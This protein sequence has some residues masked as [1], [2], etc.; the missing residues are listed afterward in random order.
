MSTKS[1]QTIYGGRIIGADINAKAAREETGSVAEM[2]VVP[3][4]ALCTAGAYDP[5]DGAQGD[6]AVSVGAS[7][8]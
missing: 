7:G 4:G 8:E 1:R 5:A 6:H 3:E 2:P